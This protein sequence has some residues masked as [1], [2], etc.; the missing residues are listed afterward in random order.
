MALPPGL[1]QFPSLLSADGMHAYVERHYGAA[2]GRIAGG[3]VV[4]AVLLACAAL[5]YIVVSKGITIFVT[6]ADVSLP[7]VEFGGAGNLLVS[8]LAIA[9]G[10]IWTSRRISRVNGAL[11]EYAQTRVEPVLTDFQQRF[12][13]STNRQREHFEFFAGKIQALEDHTNL[14][15]TLRHMIFERE[16]AR[17][18]AASLQ[19]I[20]ATYGCEDKTYNVK[21]TIRAAVVS[22]KVDMR[23]ENERFK[24][25]IPPNG[26]PCRG[27][28]KRL[29]VDYCV[30][31]GP[32]QSVTVDEHANLRLP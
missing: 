16:L 8:L 23:V 19:I 29:T 26:D 24:V 15:G 32:L 1:D 14:P 20:S 9:L 28:A 27:V 22:G 18:R 11:L 10:M 31:D 7:S 13:D 3:T 2:A 30:D 4:I 17:A 25:E 5:I 12:D 21:K 6:A